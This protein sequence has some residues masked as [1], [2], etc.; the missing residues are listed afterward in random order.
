[1]SSY[2]DAVKMEMAKRMLKEKD[3]KKREEKERKVE[4]ERDL[5]REAADL[6]N[7]FEKTR[8]VANRERM[9]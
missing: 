4:R 8:T 5:V 9:A 6:A 7:E 3:E 2:M 1:M